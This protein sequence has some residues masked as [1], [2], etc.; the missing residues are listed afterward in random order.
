M[1]WAPLRNCWATPKNSRVFA[2]DCV[3][4][5]YVVRGDRFPVVEAGVPQGDATS[6]YRHRYAAAYSM[7]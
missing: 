5:Q 7:G 6:D 2:S 1:F 4:G 3:A